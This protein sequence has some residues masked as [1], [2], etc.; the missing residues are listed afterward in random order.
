MLRDLFYSKTGGR[1]K[2]SIDLTAHPNNVANMLLPL[3][4]ILFMCVLFFVA[5]SRS[6]LLFF[7][8]VRTHFSSLITALSVW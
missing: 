2:N 5:F 8:L 1:V 3:V 6:T 7:F 4:D